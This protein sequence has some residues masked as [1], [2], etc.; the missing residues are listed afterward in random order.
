M[1]DIETNQENTNE[2]QGRFV[3]YDGQ[4][5][6]V[7][8]NFWDKD[9]N[10]VNVGALLKSQQDLRKQIS[11]DPSPKD[12]YVC[13]IPEEYKEILEA[14]PSS[15]LWKVAVAW[16]K[17]HKISQEDFDALAKP[18][19]DELAAPLKNYKEELANE[20]AK[21]DKIYGN[22]KQEVKERIKNFFKNS[23]L[24]EDAEVMNEIGI[25][26]QTAAGVRA[27][28]ALIK[29]S[30]SGMTMTSGSASA[31]TEYSKEQLRSMMK[32][33]RYWRDHEPGYVK[34][35]T[36]GFKKLYGE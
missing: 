29:K 11:S 19:F 4:K 12:G 22:K 9:K 34:I 6:E 35:I 14:D 21:L 28:D 10:E 3:E 15:P 17:E 27:L 16:A 1:P 18:Y 23:G 20:E 2:T 25:L 33:P 36:E 31:Q 24:S 5:L 32:D 30:P 8:E 7:E 13:N 26:T